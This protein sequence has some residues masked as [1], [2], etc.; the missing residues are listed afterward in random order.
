MIKQNIA[1]GIVLYSFIPRK[2]WHHYGNNI[3]ALINKESSEVLLIDA[4]FEDEMR[5]VVNDLN[6]QSLRISKIII[7]HF[8][9]DHMEGLKVV[10]DAEVFGGG[11]FQKTLDLYTQKEQHAIYTPN[12]K[13][14]EPTKLVFGEHLLEITPLPGH[15]ECT[16]IVKI[17]QSFLH[18]ADEILYSNN[19]VPLLPAFDGPQTMQRQI[20]AWEKLNTYE[21]LNIIPGHGSMLCPSHLRD[22]LRNRSSYALAILNAKGKLTLEEA[23]KDCDIEFL[24][25]NW[26]DLLIDGWSEQEND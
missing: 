15:S 8:H 5:Q 9:D 1:D 12:I 23:L 24:Q 18:V 3:L 26:F 11:D 21:N 13:I 19:G 25:T 17:N 10:K 2:K 14:S 22:D 4:G 6:S 7:S 16:V 20:N